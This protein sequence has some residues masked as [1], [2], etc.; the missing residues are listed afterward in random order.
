[1]LI[2][3]VVMPRMSGRELAER[4]LAVRPQIKVL[5]VSGY[6][7]NAIVHRGVID[8]CIAFLQKPFKLNALAIKVR[9]ILDAT[10]EE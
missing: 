4:L 1:L 7:A 3:D 6:T 9:D 8:K 2:T 10:A 5:Y